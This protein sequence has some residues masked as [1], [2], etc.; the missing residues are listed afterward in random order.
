MP[1]AR[2]APRLDRRRPGLR[3]RPPA[4]LPDSQTVLR[5]KYL[6][7][8]MA[9]QRAGW[10]HFPHVSPDP[11]RLHPK[12][13]PGY[14]GST[15]WGDAIVV[16]P[17]VLYTHYERP[18]QCL[19]ECLDA[20]VRWVDFVWSISDGP[21]VRPPSALGR[22]RLHLRRLAAARSATTASRARPVADDCAA[23]LYHFIS[24]ELAG[25]DRQRSSVSHD[26]A[27]DAWNARAGRNP[28]TPSRIEF[29]AAIRPSSPITTRR[30][31]RLA[32]LHDLVPA[33]HREAAKQPLPTAS[34]ERCGLPDRHGLHRHPRPPAGID[35]AR[36][37]RPGRKGLPA[38]R[39]SG[40]ALSG[41]KQG[42][43]TIWERWDSMAPD[44]TIYEPD[45]NSYNHYAYGAVC[46]WLFESVAGISPDPERTW[47][48]QR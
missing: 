26:L 33:A 34:I 42:A 29:V 31:T 21:I 48:C 5:G 1:P 14:A 38:G 8:V 7:D 6:R 40:L 37:G 28:T 19:D 13:F 24:T 27:P 39:G 45:M 9:D 23:T 47:F 11:T 17:W 35:Q 20:M 25:A 43:T 44:G 16:I 30:P 2:R 3:C 32:F 41:V 22:P 36:H 10:R 4:G 15:G 46:Q 12:H 18:R